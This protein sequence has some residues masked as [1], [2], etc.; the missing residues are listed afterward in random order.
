MGSGGGVPFGVNPLGLVNVYAKDIQNSPRWQQQVWSGFNVIPDGKVSVELLMAQ[1]QGDPAD[2]QAP[3]AFFRRTM[4]VLNRNFKDRFGYELIKEHPEHDRLFRIIH[5]FRS[6]D[7]SGFYA[8]AKDLARLTADSF[9]VAAL[10]KVVPLSKGEKRG[11]LRSL[12]S[13]LAT[14]VD[15]DKAHIVMTP[16]FGAYDLR[17]ADAHLPP[18]ELD[19]AYENV[20]ATKGEPWIEQG[21]RLLDSVVRALTQIAMSFSP[22]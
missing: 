2:S 8:L 3:E 4:E 7:E 19:Q 1:A 12:E 15:A 5:R 16:L 10:Q 6:V 9:D 17:L 21:A 11:S 22:K 14:E 13:V 20:N 18:S